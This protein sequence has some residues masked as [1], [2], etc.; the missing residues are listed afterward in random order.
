[1][2]ESNFLKNREQVL[3]EL[4]RIENLCENHEWRT[5]ISTVW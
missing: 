2:G 5:L 4:L 3:R 1:M